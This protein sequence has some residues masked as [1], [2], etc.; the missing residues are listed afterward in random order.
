[1]KKSIDSKMIHTFQHYKQQALI[2]TTTGSASRAKRRSLFP[3]SIVTKN[4]ETFLG[5]AD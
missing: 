1:M 4:K 3:F 5:H 2:L